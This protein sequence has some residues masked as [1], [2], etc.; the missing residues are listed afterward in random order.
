MQPS[1]KSGLAMTEVSRGVMMIHGGMTG[2]ESAF[3]SLET[4]L[5]NFAVPDGNLISNC[6]VLTVCRVSSSTFFSVPNRF[7]RRFVHNYQSRF[8]TTR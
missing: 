2:Y 6:A 5:L 8:A 7:L 1:P 4:F 3:A